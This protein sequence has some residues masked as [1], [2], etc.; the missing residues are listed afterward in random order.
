MSEDKPLFYFSHPNSEQRIDNTRL[1]RSTINVDSFI[2]RHLNVSIRRY[3]N[4]SFLAAAD[5]TIHGFIGTFESVLFEDVI[6][7]IVPKVTKFFTIT[8]LL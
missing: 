7:S 2:A 5:A 8:N 4:L 1:T 3:E 6:I